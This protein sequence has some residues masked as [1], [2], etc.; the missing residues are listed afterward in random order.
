MKNLLP[1]IINRL[2][3]AKVKY[4]IHNFDSGAVM[5]D[6]FIHDKLYVIQ[7]Y[8]DEI[9][10]SLNT[11]DTMPFDIIPDKSYKDATEFKKDFGRIF[12]IIQIP[13]IIIDCSSIKTIENFH[14]LLADKLSF[15]SFYG[16]N[17]DAFWD[18]ITGLVEMPAQL[19]FQNYSQFK[20]SFPTDSKILEECFADMILKY[21]D[22]NCKVNY[23]N[24]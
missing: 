1:D 10:L 7:I 22:I 2:D 5:V 15:P 20:N 4:E 24:N 11:E 23:Q 21:P 17:W 19:T 16:K 9:G 14:S 8:E 3:L 12:E 13:E 18:T 6:I